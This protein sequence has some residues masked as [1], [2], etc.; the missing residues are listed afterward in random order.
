MS[1]VQQPAPD[2]KAPAVMP[3][4]KTKDLSLSSFKGKK[5][6]VLFFYPFDF[7]F[8]CPTEILAFSNHIADFEARG[9]QVIGCSIDSAH[10]H[11]AWRDTPV[12]QGGIGA[13]KYPLVADVNK[14]IARSYGV[15][16]EGGM[17]LRGTFLIDKKGVV[18]QETINDLPLGRSIEEQLR[19]V[20][21]LQYTEEHGE[22]CPAGWN[23][24]KAGMKA[25][26][27]GV[28]DFLKKNAAKL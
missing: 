4:G 23:K 27:K 3:D 22:V 28:A 19:L 13:I 10:V 25:D 12:D 15:L 18:R 7:T 5:Y 26:P 21:A 8:V 16:L 14:D 1:L 6:V 24:G 11:R 17:A 9:V 2:F 20:D